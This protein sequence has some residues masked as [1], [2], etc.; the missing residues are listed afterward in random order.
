MSPGA[1]RASSAPLKAFE[2]VVPPSLTEVKST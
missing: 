2:E 1:R